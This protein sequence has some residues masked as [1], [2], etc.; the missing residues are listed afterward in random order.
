MLKI[1]SIRGNG[2]YFLDLAKSDYYTKG[3]EP[4]GYWIG[5]GAAELGIKGAV[6]RDGLR[7][8]LKGYSPNGEDQL[9]MNAGKHGRHKGYELTFNSNKDLSVLFAASPGWMKKEM[10]AA[11]DKGVA[12]GMEYLEKHGLFTRRGKQGTEAEHA[13]AIAAAFTHCTSR[14]GDVHIHTHVLLMNAARREDGTTGTLYGKV[15][16]DKSGKVIETQNPL[17]DHMK[18]A[19]AIMQMAEATELRK[20]LG[21]SLD[22]SKNGFSYEIS[23]I[24]REAVDFYSTRRKEIEELMRMKGFESAEAAQIA[25]FETRTAKTEIFRSELFPKWSNELKTKFGMSQERAEEFCNQVQTL[26]DVKLEIKLALTSAQQELTQQDSTFTE[27]E[28]YEKTA[29]HLVH[30]GIEYSDL[31]LELEHEIRNGEIVSLG[32]DKLQRFFSTQEVLKLEHEFTSEIKR[33]NQIATHSLSKASIDKAI[34]NAEKEHGF[35]YDEQYKSAISYLLTGESKTGAAGTTRVLVGDAGSGKTTTIGTVARAFE[36]EGYRVVG[37]AQAGKAA[38]ELRNKAGIPAT[39][40]A[41]WE[42]EADKSAVGHIKHE[43]RMFARTAQGKSTWQQDSTCNLDEKTVLVIDEAAMTETPSLFRLYKRAREAGS[44]VIF[45]GDQKQCQAIGQGG[46]FSLAARTSHAATI[47]GNFRQESK[48]DKELA[49]LAAEGKMKECLTQLSDRGRLHVDATKQKAIQNLVGDWSGVWQAQKNIVFVNTHEDRT[50]VNEQCQ[51]KRIASFK[52]F[53]G[54][55]LKNHE[56]QTLYKGDRVLFKENLLLH[57]QHQRFSSFVKDQFKSALSGNPGGQE[58]IRNGQFGTVLTVNPLRKEIRVKMDDGRILNVPTA[59][60]DESKKNV[61]GAYHTTLSG[62]H[63]TRKTKIALGYATTTFAGQGSEFENV[64]MLCGG[65]MQDKEQTYVQL[66]RH[67]KSLNLYT[68]ETEAGKELAIKSLLR[69]AKEQ[70]GGR[71]VF[72]LEKKLEQ[73][74]RTKGQRIEDSLLCKRMIQ[75]NEKEFALEKSAR[76]AETPDVPITV[77][78]QEPEP[79]RP[80]L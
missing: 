61:F 32:T 21:L 14:A 44:C 66:T 35:V 59:V 5:Q 1:S 25:N 20:R 74:N 78:T 30:L 23:G 58:R 16:K 2:N 18:A 19:G 77:A 57:G 55:G 69:K 37:A 63:Q 27:S 46:A 17:H 31:E 75:S 53:L 52:R 45:V 9:V 71:R 15:I 4:P 7:N 67:I 72:D 56:D 6:S 64:S 49:K 10:Q 12:A 28:L 3:G 41:K 43:A 39:T 42:I 51:K 47:S 22:R 36:K 48:E 8:M 60:R 38:D 11:H 76:L 40:L 24:S 50:Q 79:W 29:N 68:T 70:G 33:S 13:K 73:A 80:A 62:K 26:H 34:L 65:K 54:A